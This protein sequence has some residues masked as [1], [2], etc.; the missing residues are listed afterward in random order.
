MS[1]RSCASI[2]WSWVHLDKKE[3]HIPGADT[4]NGE[5]LILPLSGEV[6]SMLKKQFRKEGPVFDCTNFRKL[7]QKAVNEAKLGTQQA[8][9]NYDLLIHDLRRSGVR[10]LRQAGVQEDVFMKISGQKTRGI[11]S[12]YNIAST[13]DV[14]AAM[15]ALE[16]CN[17]IAVWDKK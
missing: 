4:K 17:S 3:V 13:K 6:V 2:Q 16:N 12:R 15:E 11:F 14:H 1:P 7:W 10:N 9:G 5:S 8:D